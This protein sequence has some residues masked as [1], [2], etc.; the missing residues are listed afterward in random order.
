M[1][2]RGKCLQEKFRHYNDLWRLSLADWKWE[3]LPGKGGPSPRSGHRMVLYKNTI[4]LFGGFFDTGKETRCAGGLGGK[5]G[6][7]LQQ[8][9]VLLSNMAA[10][11]WGA[12]QTDGQL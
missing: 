5:R 7:A 9:Q 1:Q 6:G 10:T 4:L 8:R 3:Q 12:P 11:G 2:V